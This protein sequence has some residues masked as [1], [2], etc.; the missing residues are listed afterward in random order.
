[1]KLMPSEKQPP[2]NGKTITLK[3]IMKSVGVPILYVKSFR[4]E[5]A[6]LSRL[7]SQL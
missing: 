3:A 6:G 4:G 2:G 1:M 5:G 7:K